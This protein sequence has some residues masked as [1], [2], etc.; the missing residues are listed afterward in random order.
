MGETTFNTAQINKSLFNAN[1]N[2]EKKRITNIS[3]LREIKLQ[4][5]GL[6]FSTT[7]SNSSVFFIFF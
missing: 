3:P 2:A 5:T 1:K 6:S 7:R 4:L